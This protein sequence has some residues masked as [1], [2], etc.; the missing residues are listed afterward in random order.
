MHPAQGRSPALLGASDAHLL[1]Q[2]V[3]SGYS[4]V[5]LSMIRYYSGPAHSY[6]QWGLFYKVI[7]WG[8]CVNGEQREEIHSFSSGD[9][10]MPLCKS[11]MPWQW[12]GLHPQWSVALTKSPPLA[13]PGREEPYFPIPVPAPQCIIFLVSGCGIGLWSWQLRDRTHYV[14]HCSIGHESCIEPCPWRIR[15]PVSLLLDC[16]DILVGALILPLS[17]QKILFIRQRY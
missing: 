1:C 11:W 17:G 5:S 10:P 6:C 13:C 12:L 16:D 15:K 7:K 14:G 2:L 3:R 8:Q 4:L 9:H